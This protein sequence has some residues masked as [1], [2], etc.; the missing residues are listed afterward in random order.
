MEGTRGV[1]RPEER[2]F[3]F[4]YLHKWTGKEGGGVKA[5][6]ELAPPLPFV[7]F[8][9]LVSGWN[10]NLYWLLSPLRVCVCSDSFS[11]PFDDGRCGLVLGDY[12]D[13]SPLIFYTTACCT[14]LEESWPKKSTGQQVHSGR[15]LHSGTVNLMLFF[16]VVRHV[17]ARGFDLLG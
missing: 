17:T 15:S 8:F 11:V 4:T 16:V 1:E 10:L 7:L 5:F 12:L 9:N 13:K 6:S 3:F 2:N 14:C